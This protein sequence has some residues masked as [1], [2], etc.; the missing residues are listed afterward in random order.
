[1][2]RITFSPLMRSIVA[3]RCPL[4]IA[5]ASISS[6]SSSRYAA[7]VPALLPQLSAIDPFGLSIRCFASC[8]S[9]F[10]RRLSP[11]STFPNSISAHSVLLCSCVSISF[12]L[13]PLFVGM[14]KPLGRATTN[15]VRITVPRVGLFL[16]YS[17]N[18]RPQGVGLTCPPP[19]PTEPHSAL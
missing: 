1:M 9:R 16:H 13:L 3:L 19:S 15:T 4:W 7:F 5:S 8:T 10:V 18:Y 2:A 11:S 12:I 14:D 6:L 17:Q